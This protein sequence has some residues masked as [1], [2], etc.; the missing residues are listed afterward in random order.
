M[1][2]RAHHGCCRLP[3][4]AAVSTTLAILLLQH[5]GAPCREEYGIRNQPRKRPVHKRLQGCERSAAVARDLPT[6]RRLVD[7]K[8]S[9]VLEPKHEE[10]H[11][12]L[13]PARRS[14]PTG[15]RRCL[16]RVNCCCRVGEWTGVIAQLDKWCVQIR[17]R[18]RACPRQ[19]RAETVAARRH[20]DDDGIERHRD[21]HVH[22]VR[23]EFAMSLRAAGG[24][25]RFQ[26]SVW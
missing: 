14:Q 6:L 13:V 10:R 7:G 5:L 24:R 26:Q 4:A 1:R 12:A 18:L 9:C 3:V 16:T 17:E 19:H 15:K 22:P 23:L 20:A 25:Q 11:N 21:R 8:L 2:T